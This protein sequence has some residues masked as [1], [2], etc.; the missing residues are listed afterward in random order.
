MPGSGP[1]YSRI[2]GTARRLLFIMAA[3]AGAN[4]VDD[5]EQR[6]SCHGQLRDRK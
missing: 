2:L 6:D 5:F 1:E 3:F 4:A